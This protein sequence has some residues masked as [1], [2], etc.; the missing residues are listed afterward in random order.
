MDWSTQTPP[1]LAAFEALAEAARAVLPGPFR[2][3]ASEVVLRIEDLPDEETLKEM[4]ETSGYDL[5][6]LYEG[7]PLPEKSASDPQP[8]PD[9][10]TLYRL[11][12]LAEWCERGDIA[13]SHLIEHVLVHEFAHHFGWSDED[14]ARIDRWW[15]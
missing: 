13:L 4:S 1:D 8:F 7:I 6:G 2:A 12:I 10:I 5:T 14:I 3:A 9:V 11:P 15:E